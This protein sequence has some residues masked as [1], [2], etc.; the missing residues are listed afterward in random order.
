MPNWCE[1]YLGV[2]GEKEEVKRF[3]ETGL[4]LDEDKNETWSI[5][6][7][8]PCPGERDCEWS[9]DNWGTKWDVEEPQW[10]IFDDCFFVYFQSAWNPPV[11]WLTKVQLDY[12]ALCFELSYIEPDSFCGVAYT[13]FDSEGNPSV[14]DICEDICEYINEDEEPVSYDEEKEIW[15]VN[16]TG[17][18]NDEDCCVDPINHVAKYFKAYERDRRIG[19]ILKD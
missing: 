11:E 6:P 7:Y 12:K 5:E 19:D 1:C 16:S 17:E 10:D 18:E 3:Y 13:V 2:T 15:I 14:N 4:K 9:I 8:Y